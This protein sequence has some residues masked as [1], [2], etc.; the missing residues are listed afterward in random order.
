MSTG[1]S[2]DA[3]RYDRKILAFTGSIRAVMLPPPQVIRGVS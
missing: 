1:S 3:C 2:H